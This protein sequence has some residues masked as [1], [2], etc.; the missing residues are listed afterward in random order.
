MVS[1]PV[2]FSNK[3]AYYFN[4]NQRKI[5]D[6]LL[7]SKLIRIFHSQA[8]EIKAYTLSDKIHNI[9][10]EWVQLKSYQA[11]KASCDCNEFQITESCPHLWAVIKATDHEQFPQMGQSLD[12]IDF[13]SSFTDINPFEQNRIDVL[14]KLNHAFEKQKIELETQYSLEEEKE[15]KLGFKLFETYP[16][17]NGLLRID[18]TIDNKVV[19][20]TDKLIEG[21][22]SSDKG[23]VEIFRRMTTVQSKT[24]WQR[25][26]IRGKNSFFEIP[27][28]SLDYLLPL[29]IDCTL[30]DISN[31]KLKFN[32]KE[33]LIAHSKL[34]DSTDW[35]FI[36]YFNFNGEILNIE[37]VKMIEGL[38]LALF[39]N[40][41]LKVN[42]RGLKPLFNEYLSGKTKFNK[43][44]LPKKELKSFITK[45]P[46]LANVE[47]PKSIKI[48]REEIDP[49][50]R[51][52]LD[53][54]SGPIGTVIWAQII[55]TF[56]ENWHSPLSPLPLDQ[57]DQRILRV[58]NTTKEEELLSLIATTLNL[59]LK[60]KDF[61]RKIEITADDFNNR[62]SKLIENKIEIFA[63]NKRVSVPRSMGITLK[64]EDDWFEVKSNLE[65]DEE[66]FH[67]PQILAMAKDSQALIPLKN[68]ELGL[69]PL[70]WLQRHLR[71]EHMSYMADEKVMLA[72][73]HVLYMDLLFEEKL[74]E[75]DTPSYS[76]LLTNL[77]SAK[78]APEKEIPKSFNGEL[79]DYQ[80]QGVEWLNFIDSLS[81]GGC[82][83]DEMGL[84]KTVQILCHLEI[85]RT[86]GRTKHLI[87]VPKSLIHNW[88]KEV[89][90]FCPKMTTV[91]YEG[92]RESRIKL[93]EQDFDIMFCTY[94]ITRND[95][96]ILRET[97]F[98]TII[99]DEAQH[100]KNE[101]SL[102]SKSVLLLN[103]KSRFIVTGTPIENSLSELFT[104][105]RFLS[106][107]VFNQQKISKEN[108]TDGNES[109]VEN[110]LK[111]LRPLI[112]RRLKKDVLKDL[113]DK[114]ESIL[115]VSLSNDQ[116]KIYNELK[117]HYRTKLMDKVQKVGI[118]K[119]KVHILEALLR[120]RQ[121]ACHPGLINPLYKD[122]ES[123]K[124]EILIEKLK[125]ISKS[126]EKALVFSQFTQFLK[127]V[128][129]RLI[130]EGIEFSYLDGQTNNREEVID[131]FKEQENKTAFLISLKAGGYGLN[132]TEARYCFLL[133][134]WWNPAV[135]GQAIDR[136]HRIGQK[137]EV[138]AIK[139]LSENTVEEKIVEMQKRKKQLIDNLFFS[140]ATTLKDIDSSDLVF[141]FS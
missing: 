39:K 13:I 123:S 46:N 141:L 118:K 92:Q 66:S 43:E 138:Y 137:S 95:Y 110:I 127:I 115:P 121:A 133:D 8:N 53:I 72:K 75:T 140:N 51:M 79:R 90:K 86:Q 2:S 52:N 124:L 34:E 12:K 96:E 114:N 26:N 119:S 67:T 57:I 10:L 89:A 50:I 94:G 64:T 78:S 108:L 105:F 134:P 7:S 101:S 63:K 82:L 130:K 76:T 36:P 45:H 139:L 21:L 5:G 80:K 32:S 16:M 4:N 87:I 20:V 91:V 40:Q 70:D 81:L 28:E 85:L 3:C 117:E 59:N 109:V 71:L 102:T 74:L 24:Y 100:I 93:L 35:E 42:Y 131:E 44:Q 61:S 31:N 84:G 136:I 15:K 132:L 37:E 17:Q 19:Q 88:K 62:I 56:E 106:P 122:S 97:R 41:V 27:Y 69:A 54:S 58:K 60:N 49:I 73:D 83:A 104:L 25:K 77:K 120:L 125:V 55:S 48:D 65:F 23:L 107:K 29:I 126:G 129:E 68:G 1:N 99:L 6:S 38:D 111:G 11:I 113:P 18:F 33:L 22:S 47:I 98:D 112:L 116:T 135:E 128:Q 103:S 30:I 14:D 9:S